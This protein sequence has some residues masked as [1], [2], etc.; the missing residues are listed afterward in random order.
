MRRWPRSLRMT[1]VV[2]AIPITVVT[3]LLLLTAVGAITGFN[4]CAVNPV[5][6]EPWICSND[7]RSLTAILIIAPGLPVVVLWMRFLQGISGKRFDS[8]GATS[9]VPAKSVGYVRPRSQAL[10]LSQTYLSGIVTSAQPG[11]RLV[12]VGDEA[13]TFWSLHPINDGMVKE[14]AQI[15]VVYQRLPTTN[16]VLAFRVDGS[17]HI[18]KVAA[19][20]QFA[21]M[22][23]GIA[24]LVTL[25]A[26]GVAPFHRF[27]EIWCA[28][29]V[30]VTVVHLLLMQRAV[31]KFDS[32]LHSS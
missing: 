23:I 7:A 13:L 14:R 8:A 4:D 29:A 20:A 11:V 24:A 9:A 30:V 16:Y 10:G 31:K 25:E 18:H 3:V 22:I 12:M 27:M 19:R 2:L 32:I 17:A 26:L 1:L 21:G 15:E 6:G 5:P 28:I